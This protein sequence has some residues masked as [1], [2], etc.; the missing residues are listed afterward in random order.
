MGTEPKIGG[1]QAEMG[2]E[3]RLGG[4]YAK[5][6]TEPRI[7]GYHGIMGR[8]PRISGMNARMSTE[9]CRLSLEWAQSPK[10]KES[11]LKRAYSPQ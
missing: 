6:G 2:N 4:I 10:W 9:Q 8:A 5:M 7:S 11:T 1:I 3:P